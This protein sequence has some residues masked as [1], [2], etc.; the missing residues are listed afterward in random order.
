[1]QRSAGGVLHEGEGEAGVTGVGG[2]GLG[3]SVK[4]TGGGGLGMMPELR[5]FDR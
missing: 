2:E 1:M 3:R 4:G 5:T